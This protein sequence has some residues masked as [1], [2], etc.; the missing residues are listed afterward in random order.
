MAMDAGWSVE[1]AVG[2]NGTFNQLIEAEIVIKPWWEIYLVMERTHMN[3][4]NLE[5]YQGR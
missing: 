2:S 3:D 5:A 1:T 4:S